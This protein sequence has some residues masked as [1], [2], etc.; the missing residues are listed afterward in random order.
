[1]ATATRLQQGTSRHPD[2]QVSGAEN[3]ADLADSSARSAA[4]DL[5]VGCMAGSRTA[6]PSR[7]RGREPPTDPRRRPRT[8]SPTASS[9]DGSASTGGG[10]AS[11]GDTREIDEPSSTNEGGGGGAAPNPRFD[12]VDGKPSTN[13]EK[14]RA[15]PPR[16][17]TLLILDLNH[18]LIHRVHRSKLRP[19]AFRLEHGVSSWTQGNFLVFERPYARAFLSMCFGHFH[20]AIWT[21][22]SARNA[23]AILDKLLTREQVNR[24]LFV[25]T[26]DHCDR[27]N[28]P[29]KPM[30]PPAPNPTST[31]AP[32]AVAQCGSYDEQGR[33]CQIQPNPW[34]HPPTNGGHQRQPWLN[35]QQHQQ[36]QQH[37][38]H[39]Q[40]QQHTQYHQHQQHQQHQLYSQG[41][42]AAVDGARWGAHA[43]PLPPQSIKPVFRKNLARLEEYKR[44]FPQ[45]G[46]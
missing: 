25:W 6:E 41:Q 11:G 26:Q 32:L 44:S 20:V 22:A 30:P 35:G 31:L 28:L 19:G 36:Y 33:F 15:R 17:R 3:Q 24:L 29:P 5:A 18:F 37:T 39:Q 34:C 4:F 14:L 23:G 42:P 8:Q 46:R 16:P 40:H 2:Y 9:D 43:K 12:A 7:K 45:V 27:V 13:E 1:M 21:S 10:G 38:Q